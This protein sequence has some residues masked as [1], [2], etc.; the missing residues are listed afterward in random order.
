MEWDL[1][2]ALVFSAVPKPWVT[3][4]RLPPHTLPVVILFKG[5]GWQNR[6]LC[7][8]VS[9]P[10][11]SLYQ[12]NAQRKARIGDFST[13]FLR[14]VQPPVE[15]GGIVST[16]CCPLPFMFIHCYKVRL[17][18]QKQR[19]GEFQILWFV[20]NFQRLL[21]NWFMWIVIVKLRNSF[22]FLP[23]LLQA[24]AS[25]GLCGSPLVLESNFRER[26]LCLMLAPSSRTNSNTFAL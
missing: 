3:R 17:S 13:M 9:W 5:V 2:F 6:A 21:K 8:K 11:F 12:E 1:S 20:I 26:R 19:D 18:F 25:E 22:A 7:A 15:D 16:I 23:Y 10:S 14:A 24:N 4:S